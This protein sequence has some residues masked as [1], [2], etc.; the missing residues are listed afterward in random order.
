MFPKED[1]KTIVN[2]VVE[3]PKGY[4]FPMDTHTHTE[5]DWLS[6]CRSTDTLC[7]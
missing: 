2:M 4:V 7:V 5:R 3:I 1:N 6:F